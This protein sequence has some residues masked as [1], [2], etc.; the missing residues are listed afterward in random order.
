MT[1]VLLQNVQGVGFI[2]EVKGE[3]WTELSA[4]EWKSSP[5]VKTLLLGVSKEK[6]LFP[7]ATPFICGT[8]SNR[9][10]TGTVGLLRIQDVL[11]HAFGSLFRLVLPCCIVG[12]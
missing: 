12:I 2:W 3:D 4:Q 6:T 9:F 11:V 7:E 10:Y 1:L 8:L 5:K